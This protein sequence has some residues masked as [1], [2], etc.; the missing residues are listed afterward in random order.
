MLRTCNKNLPRDI[1]LERPCLNYHIK[2]CLA[3]CTGEVTQEEYRKRIEGALEFLGGNYNPILKDLEQ[4]MKTAAEAL[5]FE[6]AAVM[7]DLYNSVKSVA[8]K[9]KITDSDGE[10]KDIV[11]MYQDGTEA[12]V[13]VFFVRD[14][15]LIGR[16]HYYMKNVDYIFNQLQI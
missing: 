1:G 5:L 9:Q 16:E 10:D 8:Q 15:K 2:Q 3:P 4:R 7:R 12:V 6:E 11:A 14:G 13:Q